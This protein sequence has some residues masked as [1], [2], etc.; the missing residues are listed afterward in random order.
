M[1]MLNCIFFYIGIVALMTTSLLAVGKLPTI[2]Q[3]AQA[4]LPRWADWIVGVGGMI[5]LAFFIPIDC[6]LK[7]F[8]A[9]FWGH[10]WLANRERYEK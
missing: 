10:V 9:G 1:T 8:W 5:A 2:S 6:R 4:L 3:R 7:V